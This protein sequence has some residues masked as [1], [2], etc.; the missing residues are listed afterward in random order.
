MGLG[1][2][3]GTYLQSSRQDKILHFE[4]EDY[5]L[6]TTDPQSLATSTGMWESA[7]HTSDWMQYKKS[8]I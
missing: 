4:Y 6:F 2:F 7:Q 8:Q 1:V 5:A 3:P